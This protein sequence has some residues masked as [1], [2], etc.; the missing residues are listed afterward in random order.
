VR[1]ATRKSAGQA[2][3]RNLRDFVLSLIL[4]IRARGEVQRRGWLGGDARASI[5][6]EYW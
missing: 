6:D 1:A 2:R 3:F 4:V 5:L